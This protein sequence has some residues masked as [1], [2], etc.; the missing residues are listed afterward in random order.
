MK[1]FFTTFCFVAFS[2]FSLNAQENSRI[3]GYLAYG[4]EIKNIGFGLNAEFPVMERLT[5]APS[6]TFFLPKEES[7]LIKTTIFELNGNANYYF[8]QDDSFGFYGLAGL[9]YT[10]V[11]VKVEDLGFGFGETSASE[12]KIGFNIGTGANFNLGKN[13]TPFAELKYVLSDF[14]QLVFMAGVKFNI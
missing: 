7:D 13:W 2:L 10:S 12:G 9:N 11:K 6:F 4:S 5:I 8:L 1:K 14:D 3:G